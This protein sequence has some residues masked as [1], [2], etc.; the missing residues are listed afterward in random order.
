M[1]TTAPRIVLDTNILLT[2]IGRQ[3]PFRWIFDCFIN[4]KIILCFSNEILFEYR[5]ILT[6]K[7]NAEIAENVTNFI[8]VSPFVERVA[9]YFNFNLIVEDADDN[10]FVAGSVGER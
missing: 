1:N 8:I 10:K 7:L 3:S 5:E 6:R 4:G 9:I 2:I